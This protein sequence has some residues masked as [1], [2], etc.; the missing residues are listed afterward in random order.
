MTQEKGT[1][2]DT[3][4]PRTDLIPA[5]AVLE[6]AK[7]MGHGAKKYA[8]FNW[9][10][11]LKSSRLVAA[12]LRHL[13]L[14]LAGESLDK[15]SGLSH[16]AHAAC[17]CLMALETLMRKPGLDGRYVDIKNCIK[18]TKCDNYTYDE[19]E[20]INPLSTRGLVRETR[21][22]KDYN[23]PEGGIIY[24]PLNSSNTE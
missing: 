7:V 18:H 15:E 4:K 16:L 12:A 20:N 2:F 9:L 3:D 19:K 24:K 14:W 5:L 8:E 23:L 11:G 22:E 1:K 21:V 17:D 6:V 10:G 13:F